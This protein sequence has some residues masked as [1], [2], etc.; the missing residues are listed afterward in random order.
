MLLAIANV[1][2]LNQPDIVASRRTGLHFFAGTTLGLLAGVVAV[3]ALGDK[4]WLLLPTQ[5][6]IFFFSLLGYRCSTAPMAALMFGVMFAFGVPEF[7]AG[8]PTSRILWA[9]FMAT[10]GIVV[11]IGVQMIPRPDDPEDA[12]LDDL[13]GRLRLAADGLD[14]LR[15]GAGPVGGLTTLAALEAQ[16]RLLGN[17]EA[18]ELFQQR[19]EEE[20]MH[21]TIAV[22][23]LVSG[24]RWLG[25]E[26]DA[27]RSG[28]PIPPAVA[29][30]MDAVRAFCRLAGRALIERQPLASGSLPSTA[31]AA[32]PIGSTGLAA[33]LAQL[34][35]A[36][37][38]ARGCLGWLG[39]PRPSDLPSVSPKPKAP[40]W[41]SSPLSDPEAVRFAIKGA[42]AA[43]LGSLLYEATGWAE[44]STNQF[45]IFVASAQARA[46]GAS[47]RDTILRLAGTVIGLTA[48]FA[49]ILAGF[50]A[51]RGVTTLLV[52]SA[53]IFFAAAWVQRSPRFA[54]AGIYIAINYG[55]VAFARTSDVP[56]PAAGLARA[57][58]LLLA[59]AIV[60]AVGALLWPSYAVSGRGS[61]LARAVRPLAAAFR[62]LPDGTSGLAAL[63]AGIAGAQQRLLDF[64]GLLELAELEPAGARSSGARPEQAWLTAAT[65]V[66]S[67]M[68]AV[69][70]RS[71]RQQESGASPPAEV[72]DAER[73]ACDGFGAALDAIAVELESGRVATVAPPPPLDAL[74]REPVVFEPYAQM[75]D[76]LARLAL[77]SAAAITAAETSPTLPAPAPRP[78]T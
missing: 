62:A 17:Q 73:R 29:Q 18:K 14:R 34:E 53:P 12:M 52:V 66:Q 21:L 46:I 39:R 15:S 74:R 54:T 19:H 37:A 11:G 50:P 44:R 55:I 26:L 42:L 69:T 6:A 58:A 63:R 16:V 9:W 32:A 59:I 8:D 38:T 25:P 33:T 75:A 78:Q 20:L 35:E 65:P 5:F 57:R 72:Q 10:L 2:F 71:I 22:Q 61:A 4:P 68:L 49:V 45:L 24:V 41:L 43:I 1:L 47:V 31:A 60:F 77:A 67:L 76:S 40:L 28:L 3:A 48:A 51:M 70:T 36:A 56:D 64:L 23:R 13:A 7:V 27:A 30:R